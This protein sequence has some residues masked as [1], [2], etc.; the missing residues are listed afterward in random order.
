M[1]RSIAIVESNAAGLRAA[2][3]RDRRLEAIEI[4]RADRPSLVGAVVKAV[5]V[6]TLP[7]LGTIVKL[8]NGPE[9]LLNGRGRGHGAPPDGGDLLVQILRDP[10]G[11][12]LGTATGATSLAGRALVHLPLESGV[13]ISRR[14]DLDNERRASLEA[15]LKALPGGWIL[16]RGAAALDPEDITIEAAALAA[17]GAAPR[18]APDAFRRLMT[19]HGHEPPAQIRV[20]GRGALKSV[21]HWCAAFA[22]AL[23]SRLEVTEPSSSL[24]DAHD[25]DNAIA[26]LGEPRAPLPNGGSLIIEATA[27]LTAIDVNAGAESNAVTTNLAAVAEIA[28]QLRLRH[29]GGLIVIDFVS[30]AR[31]RDNQK[32]ADALRA[33]LADDP[34]QTHILP[35][36]RFGLIEMTRES[37]GPRWALPE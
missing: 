32:I 21:Q 10:D 26:A 18:D 37:R 30:M 31:P 16:R 12:K 25:L 15:T 2:L 24:F 20:S 22:P 4:D 14:L 28:R 27:A 34:A 5:V 17:E 9:L 33:A 19:D 11:E 29:I 6:R 13:T 1:S 36:S 23:S 35:M 7:H 8:P 3:L